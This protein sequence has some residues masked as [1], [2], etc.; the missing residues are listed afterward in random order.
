MGGTDGREGRMGGMERC[1]GNYEV[2]AYGMEW[3]HNREPERSR[4]TSKSNY[5]RANDVGG[6]VCVLVATDS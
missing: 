4:V 6:R 1:D 5:N 2:N 3:V